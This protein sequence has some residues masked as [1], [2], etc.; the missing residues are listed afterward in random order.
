MRRHISIRGCA[1]PPRAYLC[2]RVC[3]FESLRH[4][5]HHTSQ[6]QAFQRNLV[7]N[8]GRT[9]AETW[10][11]Q[12]SS[13]E[14]ICFGLNEI[15]PGLDQYSRCMILNARACVC[16]PLTPQTFQFEFHVMFTHALVWVCVCKCSTTHQLIQQK[17]SRT[18]WRTNEWSVWPND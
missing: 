7:I 3:V 11:P 14:L 2:V 9:N 17:V 6:R 15:Q 8:P 18:N 4:A 10:Q 1:R 12:I 16:D 5:I 13:K